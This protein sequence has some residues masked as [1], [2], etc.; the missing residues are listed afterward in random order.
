MKFKLRSKEDVWQAIRRRGKEIAGKLKDQE[1]FSSPEFFSYASKLADFILRN[2]K[3][4]S[5]KIGYDTE[6]N[7]PG[8]YTDGKMIYI[9][10]GCDLVS[11]PKLLERRFKTLMGV[12]FHECA[13][14]LFSCFS[15]LHQIMDA[16]TAGKLY[17]EI[18]DDLS[19]EHQ[20]ALAEIVDVLASP[21]RNGLV[22]IFQSQGNSIDDGH[23]ELLMKRCFPGFI[24]DCITVMGETMMESWPTL[25]ELIDQRRH[26]YQIYDLLILEYAKYGY[27]KVGESTPAVEAY[28]A[29]MQ[30]VEPIVDA[31]LLENNYGLRWNYINQIML[32]LWP[33]LRD[34]FP[35][36]PQSQ[37]PS[38][39]SGNAASGSSGGSSGNSSGNA[40]GNNNGNTG[41]NASNDAENDA[42]G[43]PANGSDN[44]TGEDDGDSTSNASAPLPSPEDVEAALNELINQV[45][46]SLQIAPAP[47]NGEGDAIDPSQINSTTA[48]SSSASAL[49]QIVQNLAE[50]QAAAKIQKE[51]DKAQMEAIRNMN[52]PLVH[53]HVP[54]TVIRHNPMNEAKYK[55]IS[56][57][58]APLVRSLSKQMLDL[59]RE[60]NAEYVQHHRQFGPIIEASSAYRPDRAFFAKKKLPEDYPDMAVCILIDQSGSMCGHKLEAAIKTAILLEQFADNLGIPLM[61]AGHD[62][63]NKVR[64]RIFTDFVSATTQNDKYSLAGIDSGGC[65]RDG[66]PI[67]LCCEMLE[68]R[69]E[70]VRL[71][72]IISDGSPADDDYYGEEARK[73]ISDTVN[74]FRRKGLTIYGAAIDDDKDIIQEIY[75]KGFLSI[76]NLD[77]LPKTLVRLVR[78][79]II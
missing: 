42:N 20:T 10:A 12:L 58:I 23:D 47:I 39:Q 21:Y 51:L 24:A 71:M 1:I 63:W 55:E 48:P 15:T 13:H 3:L 67:R 72:V 52:L 17:G 35:K 14:K 57:E 46:Q 9:N 70:R 79:N 66:L 16:M 2:H 62:V 65:N 6:E 37:P 11:K 25:N 76:E 61:V 41:G 22:S 73:D 49:N 43:D 36:N 30:E 68:Q 77:L 32:F 18:P 50:N 74:Q 4:Y 40:N 38:G 54:F 78:Q 53:K 34:R 19:A 31:A 75:G 28:L 7:A 64:L 26:D 60:L 69:P 44:G 45:Q 56:S 29:K 59:F 8:G 5:L 33:T 27:Y